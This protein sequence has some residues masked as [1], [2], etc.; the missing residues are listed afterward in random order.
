MSKSDLSA[1]IMWEG[2]LWNA[3]LDYGLI[4]DDFRDA[5]YSDKVAATVDTLIDV[6][7]DLIEALDFE[8][9]SEEEEE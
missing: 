6:S 9:Y 1:K 5:G 8:G 2:G 4:G 7:K 3:I